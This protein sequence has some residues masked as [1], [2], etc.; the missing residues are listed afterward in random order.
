MGRKSD[1]TSKFF[2]LSDLKAG[3]FVIIVAENGHNYPE[4]YSA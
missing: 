1:D 3:K 2:L 4:A